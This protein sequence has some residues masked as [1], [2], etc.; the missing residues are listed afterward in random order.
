MKRV[1]LLVSAAVVMSACGEAPTSP[2]A[3]KKAPA[4]RS[5]HDDGFFCESGYVIAFDENGNPIC[6]PDPNGGGGDQFRTGGNNSS[7]SGS[8][9]PP[10][11]L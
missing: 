10:G 11:G 6:V 7:T 3:A 5:S 4:A 8:G 2:S 1:L 9:T